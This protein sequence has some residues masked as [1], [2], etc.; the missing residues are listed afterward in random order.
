MRILQVGTVDIGG[1]A[2]RVA[3]DLATGLRARGHSVLRAVGTRLGDGDDLL[4]I[5]KSDRG[6]GWRAIRA[7]AADAIG[8]QYVDFPASHRIDSLGGGAWD[9]LVIHNMHGGY[10]DLSSLPELSSRVPIVVVMHDMWLLTGH[11]AHPLG[12]D[13]W[14]RACGRCPHKATYPRVRVDVTRW[15]LRT[16]RRHLTASAV[17][18]TSPSRWLIDLLPSSALAG[19]PTRHIFNPIDTEVF[20]PRS[21]SEARDALGLPLDGAVVVC[22]Y[23]L[24]LSNPFKDSTL[25]VE[26][27]RSLRR[28]GVTLAAPG[29][30][31]IDGITCLPPANDAAGMAWLY[32]AADVVIHPA[33]A[34]TSPLTITEAG[35]CGRPVVASKVGGI[36]E[37][38]AEGETGLVV[39]PASSTSML[40]AIRALLDDP[41][42]AARM[43]RAARAL[44]ERRHSIARISE[45]WELWLGEICAE[46]A[47]TRSA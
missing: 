45:E 15:N 24:D 35:A 7:R 29:E 31:P 42:G 44:I 13:R 34:E 36:P 47:R 8:F 21:T 1:G 6:S 28:S 2:E 26:L 39:E 9:V 5:D 19:S 3:L 14:L 46:G 38:I 20:R 12:C 17:H 11:C 4:L 32:A 27:A 10:F 37:L 40:G 30:T 43:G 33:L 18:V 16:K 25:V 22:P 41:D 23:R